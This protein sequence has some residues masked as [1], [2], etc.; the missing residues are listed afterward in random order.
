MENAYAVNPSADT[1]L[2]VII[3]ESG[4]A[5]SPLIIIAGASEN[6]TGNVIRLDVTPP[7]VRSMLLLPAWISLFK[8]GLEGHC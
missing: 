5:V 3:P 7:R 8:H 1:S 6:D 2:A 4:E